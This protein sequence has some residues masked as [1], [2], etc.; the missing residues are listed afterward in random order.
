MR[1]LSLGCLVAAMLIAA[2]SSAPTASA[3]PFSLTVTLA[4]SPA[5]YKGPCPTT[6]KFAGEISGDPGDSLS[7][8]ISRIVGGVPAALPWTAATIPAVGKIAVPDSITVTAAQAGVETETLRAKPGSANASVKVLVTCTKPTPTPVATKPPTSPPTTPPTKPPT[9]KPS[10]VLV[11]PGLSIT[12]APSPSSKVPPGALLA[13]SLTLGVPQPPPPPINLSQAFT[14][15]TCQAHGGS[16]GSLACYI[17]LPAGK[18]ALV[19]DYP[20]SNP[21]DGYNIYPAAG[22]AP[23]GPAQL[24]I[25]T[26]PKPI[27][28]QADPS[29][30][31]VVLDMPRPGACFTVTAYRGKL[32]SNQS[33]RLC[34]G[35]GGI[36]QKVSLNPDRIGTMVVDFFVWT[37]KS[38]Q[39]NMY[40]NKSPFVR[41]LLYLVVGY[42][43]SAST[44]RDQAHTQV[45][46]YTNSL[47]R[48]YV[49][50][51]TAALSGHQIAQAQLSLVGG[52]TQGGPSGQLCLAHYGAADR[53]WT[54][55]GPLNSTSQ[56]GN[57]PY[58]GPDLHL[59]VT[60][61]VQSWANSPASNLGLTMDGEQDLVIYPMVILSSTCLTS[62][63]SATLD[64][65]YY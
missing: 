7:Y 30:K 43:H 4:A 61:L 54:P 27:A 49:H 13:P 14:K 44:F 39:D 2:F 40:A 20:Y 16:A 50:F 33:V 35:A 63:P 47:F 34:L 28:T 45:S 58:Q 38:V 32:E 12:P 52:S 57:G 5:S 31:F 26:L 3:K 65:T 59:D 23:A 15:E 48:G 41:D 17:G 64:V 19:W 53:L 22:P 8:Q 6:I 62:F 29:W 1:S 25:M 10:I 46:S 56:L 9:S 37:D 36:A 55:G 18:L 21:I 11:N 51:N 42:D 60:S 24:H